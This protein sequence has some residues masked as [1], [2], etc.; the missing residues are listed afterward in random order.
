MKIRLEAVTN[1]EREEAA[2]RVRREVFGGELGIETSY[3]G[4]TDHSR[5]QQVIARVLPENEV[6][7]TVTV[8]DT[9]GNCCLHEKYGL[10]FGASDRVA[11]YTHMAVLKPYRG[12]SLPLYMLLEARQLYIVPG[13]FTYTWLLFP[14]DRAVSSTFCTAL[15]FLAGTGIVNGE[16]GPCR[17]LLRNEKSH[18]AHVAE[19][20]TRSFLT[21]MQSRPSQVVPF[22]ETEA[23]P[24]LGVPAGSRRQ[25]YCGFVRE[26]EWLGH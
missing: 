13:R 9:T 16:Q 5:I 8:L 17:V 3:S 12:L 2:S 1:H 23:E 11:R 22:S 21:F 26:D 18:Q 20:Q 10:A 25:P 6:I 24:V 19:V 7:A 14:A 4:R 15:G